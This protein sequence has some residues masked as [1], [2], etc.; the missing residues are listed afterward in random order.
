MMGV[1]D[2]ENNPIFADMINES[3]SNESNSTIMEPELGLQED[4][5]AED[6]D[7]SPSISYFDDDEEDVPSVSQTETKSS[8]PLLMLGLG[9]VVGAVVGGVAVQSFSSSEVKYR[10]TSRNTCNGSQ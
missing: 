1:L 5:F 9:M 8:S 6:P 7:T 10:S 2:A 4:F 3:P